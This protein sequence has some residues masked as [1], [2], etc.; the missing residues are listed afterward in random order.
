MAVKPLP[1]IPRKHVRRDGMVEFWDTSEEN[2]GPVKLERQAILAR[3]ALMNDPD[4]YKLELPRG[5]K[6]GPA[7]I[8]ADERRAAEAEEL[9]READ[10]DPHYGRRSQP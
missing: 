8:E 4:R 6:P 10:A 1:M 9:A 2:G 3:E 5:T 7:Q